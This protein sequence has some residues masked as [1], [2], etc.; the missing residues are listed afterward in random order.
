MIHEARALLTKPLDCSGKTSLLSHKAKLG[1]EK[2][3]EQKKHKKKLL[4][5]TGSE[6]RSFSLILFDS[7]SPLRLMNRRENVKKE[8]EKAMKFRPSV[9]M[10][11][12]LPQTFGV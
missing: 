5:L 1:S 3:M 7:V 9:D 10:A 6:K 8:L 12:R 2:H 4:K 11:S